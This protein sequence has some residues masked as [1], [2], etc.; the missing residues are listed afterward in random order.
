MSDEVTEP[1]QEEQVI[2]PVIESAPAPIISAVKEAVVPEP[3]APKSEELPEP[4]AEV[5]V[6][7]TPVRHV[8]SGNATDDV[9][10][11]ACV[12]MN[13]FARKSLTVHHVQRRLTELGFKDAG[14]DK[15]GWYGELTR[16]SV[17]QFQKAKGIEGDGLMNAATF[18]ALFAGDS[19][20]TVRGV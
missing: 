1:V 19:N 4:V 20:V 14:N 18:S 13:K 7:A 12:Y 3:I 6:Q 5:F 10:L 8:V 15:D 9:F 2:T 11:E 17:A 16:I